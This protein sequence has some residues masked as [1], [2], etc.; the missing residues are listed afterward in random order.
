ME[1]VELKQ[2]LTR[3]QAEWVNGLMSISDKLIPVEKNIGGRTFDWFVNFLD[4]IKQKVASNIEDDRIRVRK[5]ISPDAAHLRHYEW[6]EQN[7]KYQQIELDTYSSI[8]VDLDDIEQLIFHPEHYR[9]VE[10]D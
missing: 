10:V 5:N 3:E 6:Y 7:D 2:K 4:E 9:I 1:Q 8:P